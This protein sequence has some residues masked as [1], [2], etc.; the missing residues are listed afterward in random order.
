MKYA[1]AIILA[2]ANNDTKFPTMII[3]DGKG[4]N[5]IKTLN[6][7][8]CIL[9]FNFSLNASYSNYEVINNG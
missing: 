3:L 8:D 9:C 1:Y 4:A 6:K 5:L 7:R 2:G